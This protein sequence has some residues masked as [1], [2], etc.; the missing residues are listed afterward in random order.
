MLRA[1]PAYGLALVR[2][3]LPNH[4]LTSVTADVG[5]YRDAKT[6]EHRDDHLDA[7]LD[8]LVK[9]SSRLSLSY[10][11]GRPFFLLPAIA[12]NGLSD[13]VWHNWQERGAISFITGGA[14]WTSE[15]RWGINTNNQ[16]R[17]DEALNVRDPNRPGEEFPF[18]R[19]VGGIDYAP[20]QGGSFS[21]ARPELWRMEG[22]SWNLSQVFSR[23]AGRHTF[24]FGGNFLHQCCMRIKQASPT[25]RYTS[26]QDLLNNVPS[27]IEV[28][29][30]SN[31]FRGRTYEFG[32]FGQDDCRASRKLVLNL[33]L[34]YDFYS[35]MVARGKDG[36]DAG[37][38]NPDGLLDTQFHVGPTR[39]PNNPY[40]NDG[41]LNFGPRLGFA[42][43]L[44][45][46][47][48]TVIRGGFGV[49]FSS[50]ILGAMWQ[51]VGSKDV[52]FRARFS[53]ADAKRL[54]LRWPMF[55]DDFRNIVSAQNRAT[56]QVSVFSIFNP[57]LQNPYAMQY[58]LGFE[59]Q[60]TSTLML[61]SAFVGLRGVKSLMH[62]WAN[63]PDRLTGMRPN[64]RLLVDYY[65]DH[66]QLTDYA[67]WQ[68]SLRKRF[69]AG[70]TGSVHYTWGKSLST[71]G[72]DIGTYYQGDA[73][74]RTQ[75]FLNPS[76]DRGPSTGD[77]THYF[78]TEW[79]YE[80]PFLSSLQNP[81]ARHALRG[82]Q[83]SGIFTAR[84]GEPLYFTQTSAIE[85]SRPDFVGGPAIN[86]NYRTTLQYLNPAAFA[87]VPISPTSKATVQPG[88]VG[89]GEFRAPGAW[90][91][92]LG[93]AKNFALSDRF[94]LQV[95]S[96]IFNALNHT[97]LTGLRTNINDARFG[98]LTS[99]GGAR[100]I[101]LNGRLSW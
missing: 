31:P 47:G 12:P 77:L 19:R 69:S 74:A 30:G 54:G 83:V 4:T 89:N 13:R 6:Q 73:D 56:G 95:R 86:P 48:T 80:L 17:L 10:S 5:V 43:D 58:T 41:S 62:R 44:N 39:N 50:Q 101:Q 70:L 68:T 32:F 26:K 91:V 60:V 9:R 66:S 2:M 21:V 20:T 28:T 3:P 42:Y 38:Y 98:Q 65:L 18:G 94:K 76:A 37:F 34:R 27:Q 71:A 40:E 72:G 63:Q 15:S 78:V 8:F 84:T 92:D 49:L 24:K 23:H 7:K 90:N 96:D 57:H 1:L 35:N 64:P 16:N 100:V 46:R 79:L 97:N 81:I 75:E 52:P 14:N 45:G 93:L 82:W 36:L 88:T 51:A 67:S 53:A 99:T 87:K 11:R 22:V 85:N 61:E 33:G 59:G 55:N 25:F 29:F